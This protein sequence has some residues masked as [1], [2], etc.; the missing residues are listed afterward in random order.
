MN[1]IKIKINNQESLESLLQKIYDESD[2]QMNQA[3]EQ[4]N[5]LTTS[6]D[7]SEE[8]LDAKTKYSKAINDMLSIKEKMLKTKIEIGKLLSEVLKYNGDVDKALNEDSSSSSFNVDELKKQI[9]D[10][11]KNT[12]NTQKYEINK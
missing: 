1:K 5:L 8:S 2:M 9:T 10:A 3:Q 7:L 12:D 6:S 4:I 11:Y